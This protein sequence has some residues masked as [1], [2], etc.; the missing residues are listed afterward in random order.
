METIVLSSGDSDGE[1]EPSSL[2]NRQSTTTRDHRLRPGTAYAKRSTRSGGSG[3]ATLPSQGSMARTPP[4]HKEQPRV[5]PLWAQRRRP[6]SPGALC[7]RR[8][9]RPESSKFTTKRCDRPLS[10]SLCHQRALSAGPPKFP[11]K[12]C[13]RPLSTSCCHLPVGVIQVHHQA[14]RSPS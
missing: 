1:S 14:V 6:G 9:R 12:Q 10:T 11:T 7:R 8:Q 4:T 2:G 13:D 5:Q 3:R